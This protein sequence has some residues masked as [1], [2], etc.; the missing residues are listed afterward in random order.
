MLPT[1]YFIESVDKTRIYFR[2]WHVEKPQVYIIIVHGLGDHSGR[3]NELAQ[4]FNSKG[5]CVCG[6][7]L[8]GHGNS[9]GR[10]GHVSSYSQYFKDIDTVLL[11]QKKY[12]P[13]AHFILYGHGLGGNI[14]LSYYFEEKNDFDAIIITSPWFKLANPFSN[15]ILPIIDVLRHIAPILSFNNRLSA[16]YL[17][18]NNSVEMDY[19]KDPLVHNKI[20]VKLFYLSSLVGKNISALGYRIN[21]PLLLMHGTGDNITSCKASANFARN[22]GIYTTYKEWEGAF[23]ELHNE[24]NKE[25]VFEFIINW[26]IQVKLI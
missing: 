25:E 3:Y 22:T 1:G 8:R 6:F 15:R 7:D 2:Y 12:F 26:M 14:A 18:R 13:K 17:S 5:I 21:V 23:H 20:S 9:E 11:H 24:T 10:R 19:L 16:K 4:F